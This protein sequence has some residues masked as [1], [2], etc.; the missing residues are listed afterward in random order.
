MLAI[1]NISMTVLRQ[2][3]QV[4]NKPIQ[5]DILLMITFLIFSFPQIYYK[6]IKKQNYMQELNNSKKNCLC[7][8]E[9]F[10]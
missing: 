2:S 9:V 7:Y 4:T 3:N 8:V 10:N 6:L 1:K 5:I